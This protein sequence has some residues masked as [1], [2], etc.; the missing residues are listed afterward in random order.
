MER[1]IARWS[2]NK[3]RAT[4]AKDRKK[5]LE[6][7]EKIE[8]PR[9]MIPKPAVKLRGVER[10]FETVLTVADLFKAFDGRELFGGINLEINRGERV[11]V[12][13]RNG[14]GKTTFLRC[15]V[16]ENEPDMGEVRFGG[17]VKW[18]YFSQTHTELNYSHT[19]LEE[20][21]RFRP[22]RTEQDAR[23][24]LG[25][26]LFNEDDVLKIVGNIS[27]G[28]RSKLALAVL[29][30]EEPNVLL[31]DEPTNHLDIPSREALETALVQFPGTIVFVSH[32]RRFID[33]LADKVLEFGGGRTELF[34][35]NYTYY[36]EKKLERQR[37]EREAELK[38]KGVRKER[39][40]GEK[41]PEPVPEKVKDEKELEYEKVL[42]RITALEDE[43]SS[44]QRKLQTPEVYGDYEKAGAINR[45]L[46]E[47]IEALKR[48][49]KSLDDLL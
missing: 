32:D 37:E 31:L 8:K 28:E 18:G 48:E 45:Q 39:R 10:S 22:E 27:G 30:D 12:V 2:A 24:R 17:K 36:H 41:G 33:C 1:F 40:V 3:I 38:A 11:A 13:G 4:Q 7:M 6:H 26:F 9:E 19:V 43:I 16:G 46:K 15:L 34:Y 29:I 20:F 35:G 14:E 23:T 25:S 42:E 47:L 5:K 44:L 21:M 49:E